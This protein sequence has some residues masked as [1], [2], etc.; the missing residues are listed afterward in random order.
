MRGHFYYALT[1]VR[2]RA[3]GR[4]C[5]V[6]DTKDETWRHLNFCR[7]RMLLHARMP[8]VRCQH[9]G[10]HKGGDASGSPGNGLHAF[11]AFALTLAR[12]M[13]IAKAARLLDEHDTRL[14]RW[15]SG[16]DQC[17]SRQEQG[18]G[19]PNQRSLKPSSTLSLVTCSLVHPFEMARRQKSSVHKHSKE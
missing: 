17:P 13:P 8:R 4:G 12:A 3:V 2:L 11:E 16:G 19:L 10:G 14:W 9:C 18:Q 6:N 1:A 5:A 7:R 15:R